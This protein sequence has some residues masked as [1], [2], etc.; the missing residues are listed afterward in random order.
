MNG[1]TLRA[2][3]KLNLSLDITGVRPDG[4]HTM[5]MLMQAVSLYE[6]VTVRRSGILRVT[7][8]GALLPL[9]EKNTVWKAA[10][11]F[12]Q[13]VGLLAGAEIH[14]QK[15]TPVRAGMGGGSADAAAV[16]VGLNLLYGA[17]LPLG[18]LCRIGATIGADVPFA[19]LGGTARV[20]GVGDELLVLPPLRGCVFVVCM[21]GY[22]IST[23]QAFAAYD[24]VGAGRR[25]DTDAAEAAL[26]AGSVPQL[27]PHL[28]N[29]LQ[30]ASAGKDTETI[31]R[32]LR[33]AG[34]GAALMTGSGAATYGVFT[35]E[36]TARAGLIA[37][38]RA[39]FKQMW[40]LRPVASGPV[41]EEMF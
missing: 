35:D 17:K 25:P 19:L 28:A 36:R 9:G 3:A 18:E 5:D 31:C 22:G 24:E 30:K 40:L 29:A 8:N 23:P 4:Y 32:L 6:R 7:A 39:G 34:A 10:V 38:R 11:A 1:V 26:R 15:R 13:E 12:L 27:L 14:L 21:P 41:V 16:L 20:R 37:L 33:K 2:P